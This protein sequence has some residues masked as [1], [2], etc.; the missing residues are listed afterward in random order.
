MGFNDGG[1]RVFGAKGAGC[2]IAAIYD[3]NHSDREWQQITSSADVASWTGTKPPH[4][5]P[6]ASI[7]CKSETLTKKCEIKKI[8]KSY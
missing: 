5:S 6:D 8:N 3:E 1:R 2:M 7:P 4:G